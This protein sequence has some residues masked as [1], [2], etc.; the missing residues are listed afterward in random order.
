MGRFRRSNQKCTTKLLR[1]PEVL[2][3]PCA[4]FVSLQTVPAEAA[5]SS[6]SCFDFLLM[7]HPLRAGAQKSVDHAYPVSE[8][9]PEGE[10]EPASG[11]R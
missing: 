3:I 10:T 8:K 4:A 11:H 6:E 9:N 7:R 5:G 2:A 1:N